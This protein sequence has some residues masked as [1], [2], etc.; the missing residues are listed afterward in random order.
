M[1]KQL[2]RMKN[3][4][5]NHASENLEGAG[6]RK[7]GFLI[8]ICLLYC[9]PLAS[10]DIDSL[11]QIFQLSRGLLDR[12]GDTYA[13]TIALRIIIPD[14]PTAEQLAVASDIAARANLE[15]L[16]ID[17]GLV[18]KESDMLTEENPKRT[19]ILI[20]TNL[21]LVKTLVKNKKLNLENLDSDQ[22]LISLYPQ[23]GQNYIILAAGSEEALLKTGRAFF[24][25][26]PYLWDIWGREEGDTYQTVE[27]NL[28]EFLKNIDSD[29]KNISIQSVSYKFPSMTSPHDA[30]KRLRFNTGE[31]KNLSVRIDFSNQD[32]MENARK[33]FEALQQSHRKGERTDVL[34]YSGCS[35]ISIQ[36]NSEK[37][38]SDLTIRR[39]GL[40]KRI[41]TPSYKSPIKPSRSG[42][43]FDLLN[44]FSTQGVFLDRDKD[45]H[46]DGLDTR[47]IISHSQSY[48]G[49]DKLASRLVLDTT[50]ASFPIVQLDTEIENPKALISPILI[51]RDNL[52][53]MELLKTAKLKIPHLE[54]GWGAVTV[55]PE[56]FNKSSAL[57]ITGADSE[58]MEKTLS[59]LS[60]TFPYLKEFKDGEVRIHD[61]FAQLEKFFKGENGTAEAYFSIQLKTTLEEIK[62]KNFESVEL[63]LYLP[64]KNRSFEKALQD[65]L[66]KTLRTEKFQF[67]SFAL[68]DNK[69]IFE[70]QKAFAWEKD[71]ALKKIQEAAGQLKK[72]KQPV[73]ISV[74][75]SESP[76]IRQKF[77]EDIEKL[78]FSEGIQDMNVEVLS[79]YKQGF[80]WLSEK[81]IPFLKDQDVDHLLIRFAEV[82]DD[83]N[84]PKRFYSDPY[85]WLQELYPVDE[86]I[87]RDTNITLEKIEFEIKNQSLPVYEAL[88]FD[89]NNLVLFQETFSPRTREDFYLKVLPE[90]GNIKLTTGWVTVQQG[91]R[92]ILDTS[93]K[94]DMER[95]WDFYQDEVLPEVYSY[96]LKKTGNKPVFTKQPYFKR[97]LVELW[98]SEPDYR[99][100]LDEEII[101]SLESIHDELYF[102]T[103]D[104]IRGITEIELEDDSLAEDSSRYSAPGN[105]L[106]LIHPSTEGQPG[107]VK[108]T[109]EDWQA[110]SPQLI[111][112]WKEK[113]RIEHTKKF[114]F[115]SLTMEN[116]KVPTFVFNGTDKCIEQLYV[117]LNFKKETEY[118]TLIN[119]IE[120]HR[121]L[122]EQGVLET[123]FIFPRLKSLILFLKFEDLV[124]EEM[125]PVFPGEMD[126]RITLP[127]N[128]PSTP[129]TPTDEIISPQECLDIVKKLGRL[130]KI[131]TYI[132]GISFENRKIPVLE[133]FS[134]IGK[135]ISLP[136]LITFKPTLYLSGRQH[137]NEV[138]ATN[139]ILKF[140]ELL[141]TDDRYLEYTKKINFIL[142]PMENPDG[143]ALAYNLQKLTP[144]HSLHAGRYTS[145]GIDVSNQVGSSKPLLPEA[146][147]RGTLYNKWLPD[148]YLNL[149]GYPSHEWVQ[150]F[151][152]YSPYLFRDYWIPR[153]WF[154]YYRSLNL[155]IY[156]KW[157]LAGTQLKDT[158]IRNMTSNPNIKDSNT[159]FYDRYF[160]WATRWQPHMNYLER[161]EGLNIYAKRRS[162]RASRLSNRR[163]LTFVEE[164]PELMDETARGPWLDFLVTQGLTYLFAH[165]EYLSQ[166]DYKIV[167][168]EEEIQGRVSIQFVRDRPGEIK[169]K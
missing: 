38:H 143:A 125:F 156:Q 166:A 41:L 83:F 134:P 78:L 21:Y 18:Q 144:F 109:F 43:S 147:V 19:S 47:L 118:T 150:Q 128:D 36:M 44:L 64:Q 164:T 26:W 162:S 76:E 7:S 79:S 139:Y 30:V 51:G 9:L 40:P 148:I 138:S 91:S 115:P 57:V 80:F 111:L 28:E 70:K 89:Q 149:H 29:F 2:A 117:E 54:K 82:N 124:K 116:P 66:Q 50:G 155:P 10:A 35:Q 63:E 1:S 146:K 107:R 127:E 73:R 27:E 11:S 136:R 59:Y 84:Q 17:F 58:G 4:T 100:G 96:I 75:I 161:D 90:W 154:A 131:Q 113:D 110:R 15:S 65:N 98:L 95:F 88:A 141:A 8:M 102:D 72:T 145:L 135:Y 6:M 121:K 159:K 157:K 152:N 42:K 87:A 69:V 122:K 13:E 74:G 132:A 114:V 151:S 142:H 20:G 103:L 48:P 93:L 45:S 34:N 52:L 5:Y 99:L 130:D 120:E 62:D 53:S 81:I 22:G 85:R 3:S 108:V 163:K 167:R 61:V 106:P 129:I 123:P 160:R 168:I 158:I 32:H 119:I 126:P 77:K 94:T 105:I 133:I 12:D 23:N 56:A 39:I 104:F 169:T 14:L 46:A 37:S 49:T 16:V 86:I 112:K 92:T 55:V 31:I 137:A 68:K 97:L 60:Q 25:R 71:E 153:G 101:S 33:A 165:V 24:L 140:A 67:K